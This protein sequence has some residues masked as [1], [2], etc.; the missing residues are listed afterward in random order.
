M[1]TEKLCHWNALATGIKSVDKNH[2][3]TYHPHGEHSSSFWFHNASW[4]DFNMCQSGHAQQDFAIYQRL[5]LPDLKRNHTSHAWTE[6]PDM[7]IFRSISK[8]KM[9]DLEMMISAIHFTKVCSAEL[10]DIHTAVMI[11]GRCLIPDVSLNVTPTLHG[12]NQW[13]NKEHGT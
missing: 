4:L 12:T 5:L 2:L 9:E 7:K 3:M 13:I 11:Y 10:V 1:E 6:N 8:K